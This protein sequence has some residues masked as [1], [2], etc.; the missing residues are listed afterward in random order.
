MKKRIISFVL[1]ICILISSLS[2]MIAYA[3]ADI[4]VNSTPKIVIYNSNS[5]ILNE[6]E[7]TGDDI[8]SVLKKSFAYCNDNAG[9][10]NVLTIKIPEGKYLIKKTN[11]ASSNT[12]LDLTDNVVIYNACPRRGN[13][14]NSPNGFYGYDGLKNFTVRGGELTYDINNKNGSTLSR[15]AHADNVTFENVKFSNGYKSHFVEVAASKNI[16][17]D[18]C[19]F[20]GFKGNLSSSGCEAIQIDILEE[21]SHFTGFPYYDGTMNSNITVQN[22]T[23]TNIVSGVGTKSLYY[24]YYQSKIN[25]KNN[26]FKNL[27]G[28]A[29]YCSGYTNCDI[30]GNTITNC[31]EGINYFMMKP[32]S[33]LSTV[34]KID[35][36]GSINNNC[37][38]RIHDNIISVNSTEDIS[39]ASAIYVFGNNVTSSKKS[40]YSTSVKVGNYRVNKIQIYNNTIKTTAHGIRV[41]DT[42]NSKI[43]GNTVTSSKSSGGY[44][45]YAANSS[46]SNQIYSNKINK[47]SNGIFIASSSKCNKVTKN[48]VNG[49][50]NSGI[51]IN[52]GCDSNSIDSNTVMNS[53]KNG[54][55]IGASKTSSVQ[56]NN[57][58]SS[59]ADA[60][61]LNSK[62]NV[63]VIKGNLFNVHGKYAIYCDKGSTAN[64]Y[65]NNYKNSSGRYGYSK[66]DKKD[67]KFANL[68]V[69]TVTVSKKGTT[70][71]VSWKKVGGANDYYVYRSTS[72][73]GTYSYIGHTKSTKFQNKKLKKGKKYYYKVSA[74]KVA[75]G[76]KQR[77]NLSTVKGKKI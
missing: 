5:V 51:V 61:H 25:I 67:Y 15:I 29:I 18:R 12:I 58:S 71:T 34:C 4:E 9:L 1:S 54:I 3:E 53:G 46:N 11:V 41:Y 6:F 56:S 49:T 33:R 28:T 70:A 22:C 16:K 21:K 52:S 40:K 69:P 50:G 8:T 13:I 72:K 45:I 17:F 63:N 47:F 55:L 68:A 66:G 77:S 27:T 48:T 62:A 76:I 44:G 24:G 60:I 36:L 19:T 23:F 37:A 73:N 64:V 7:I 32:D 43:F 42:T 20:D 14:I 35:N 59:K 38:T 2:T 26:T 10:N 65:V 57:I 31:A 30:S 74:V 75:N 39:T